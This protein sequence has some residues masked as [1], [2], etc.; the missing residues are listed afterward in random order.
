VYEQKNTRKKKSETVKCDRPTRDAVDES[1]I[2]I[3]HS[4]SK[5]APY[6]GRMDERKLLLLLILFLTG[7]HLDRATASKGNRDKYACIYLL[8]QYRDPYS[9]IMR[10]MV[11]YN[12]YVNDRY[13]SGSSYVK[14]ISLISII[15]F[16]D[17]VMRH[18]YHTNNASYTINRIYYYLQIRLEDI[19]YHHHPANFYNLHKK[20]NSRANIQRF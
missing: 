19:H 1:L 7:K 3:Q 15:A 10:S 17:N 20:L 16:V 5:C 6:Y 13:D 4:L 2:I 18:A 14:T 9:T 11:G 12:I 8:K